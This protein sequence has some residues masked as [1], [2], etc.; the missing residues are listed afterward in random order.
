MTPPMNGHP[1][2]TSDSPPRK[3]ALPLRLRGLMKNFSV[4]L[5]PMVSVTPARNNTCLEEDDV[6][7]GVGE[8]GG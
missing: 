7:V 4:R 6:G 2:K 1:R 8:Q 3:H 5:G